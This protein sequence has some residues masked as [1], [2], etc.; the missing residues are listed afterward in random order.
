M[1]LLSKVTTLGGSG[2]SIIVW[3]PTKKTT[4]L[5][6]FEKI[7]IKCYPPPPYFDAYIWLG[8]VE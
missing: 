1:K 4:P 6:E 7:K 3:R 8:E 2:G 5:L